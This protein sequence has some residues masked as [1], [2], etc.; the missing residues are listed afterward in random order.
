MENNK[1]LK[2]IFLWGSFVILVLPLLNLPPWLS[3]PDW[4]KTIVF[5]I[6]FS[7]LLFV[8]AIN[9]K[10]IPLPSLKKKESIALV[11]LV[12]LMGI[13][14]LATLFSFDR[15][16]S[17]WGTPSRS[18]GF[19]NFAFI[20]LFSISAFLVFKPKDWQRAWDIA[21]FVG[22]ALVALLGVFQWRGWFS[23]I[24]VE[25]STR[26]M[27]TLGNDIQLGIYLILLL[28]PALAFGLQNKNVYKKIPY[29]LCVL[30]FL[31]VIVLTGSRGAYLGIFFG[32]SYFILFYPFKKLS[33]SLVSKAAFFCV[34]LIPLLFVW[35]VNTHSELPSFV[36]K[37]VTLNSVAG[38][39]QLKQFVL[40]EPRFS[41]WR[42]GWE[43]MKAR[44]LLGYGPENFEVAFDRY[45]DP[46]YPNIEYL[47]QSSN[48]WWDRAH[49]FLVDNASQA[50]VFAVLVYLGIFFV[51]IF[52]LQKY[53]KE[54]LSS[55][56]IAHGLQATFVA[57]LASVFWG[58]DTFSTY[59]LSF[60]AI[61]Y[62]MFLIQKNA[63]FRTLRLGLP[64]QGEKIAVGILLIGLIWFNWQFNIRPLKV[65]TDIV[66][67]T[68]LAQQKQCT[69]AVSSMERAQKQGNTFLDAYAN[70]RYF[71][72]LRGCQAE[73]GE[74]D[75][76]TILEKDYSLMKTA[77]ALWPYHTRNWIFLAQITS[78]LA[79]QK[80]QT[81]DESDSYFEK[82]VALSPKHQ[83]IYIEWTKAY[84]ASQNW[85][86]AI[87][88][89][90]AC[91]RIDPRTNDCW[92][93]KGL[94]EIYMGNLMQAQRDLD[95]AYQRGLRLT[96]TDILAKLTNAYAVSK[97]FNEII[98]IYEKLSRADLDNVQYHASLAAAYK[99]VGKLSEAKTQALRVLQLNPQAK[100]EV[101]AFLKSL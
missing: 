101:N 6:I 3:P 18:G 94:T 14:F 77:S 1:I 69:P 64:W 13:F 99:E 90:N 78:I 40:Q 86:K 80:K 47:P 50:G 92:W 84:M 58:F 87:E 56:L 88:K 32:F 66:V 48:S 38:R 49:N 45:Y 10:H 97:H 37:N 96:N 100:D 95:S 59:L 65:N 36:Q 16:F 19:V 62:A 73:A 15:N 44:P 4:G 28:F 34:L 29:L 76:L 46:T 24:L 89:A 5:R 33:H 61:A 75:Q 20:I 71:D 91:I 22:G 51:L 63:S 43:A 57:Y 42:V 98:K 35:F 52:Q 60:F 39:L 70:A 68:T 53:K 79:E 9:I 85:Q 74:K 11:L 7:A 81:L 30:L 83:E 82:S 2:T 31:F 27:S 67:G 55:Q 72:V 12:S 17:L 93:L 8:L 23:N 54:N 26:P 25:K 41:T 21:I